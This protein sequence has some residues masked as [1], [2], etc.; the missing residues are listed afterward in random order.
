MTE[1]CKRLTGSK[2]EEVRQIVKDLFEKTL[3]QSDMEDIT[4]R[5]G[6]IRL[7]QKKRFYS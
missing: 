4:I 2:K 1:F 5:T 3:L 7:T 6:T